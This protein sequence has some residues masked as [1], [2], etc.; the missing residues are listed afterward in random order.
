LKSF[1]FVCLAGIFL[2]SCRK[3]DIPVNNPFVGTWN[4]SWVD[5]GF[6]INPKNGFRS[7]GRLDYNGS[8]VFNRDST[9]YLKG[10]VKNIT[11]QQELFLW[12]LDLTYP[13][14][15]YILFGFLN[16]STRAE[17]DTLMTDTLRFYFMD[18][19]FAPN[20]LGGRYFYHI[21]LVREVEK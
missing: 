6:A 7:E 14:Y 18:Y 16:G 19:N 3:D 21:E 17:I 8:F 4:I 1:F 12:S 9:G 5:S 2:L 10:S 13:G 20:I 15:E 11:E